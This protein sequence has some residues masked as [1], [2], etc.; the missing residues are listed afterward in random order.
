MGDG[1]S[2]F[3]FGHAFV[4]NMTGNTVL[5]GLAVFQP[6]GDWLHPVI[7][8]SSYAAGTMIGSRLTQKVQPGAIWS[9]AISWTLL[10]EAL[11]LL[12]AE[13]GSIRN[14]PQHQPRTEPRTVAEHR[15]ARNRD[16]KQRHGAVENSRHRHHLHHRYMDD[17]A[18]RPGAFDETGAATRTR[19]RLR[20]GWQCRRLFCRRTFSRRC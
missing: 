10:L 4:A 15:C 11:L 17:H 3:G 7:S 13:T 14:S 18:K 16:A 9:K 19:S 12:A 8:L 1:W 5:L 2:Y 6:H 20:S